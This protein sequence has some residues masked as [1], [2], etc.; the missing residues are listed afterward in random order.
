MVTFSG[1]VV[2]ITRMGLTLKMVT[3]AN[4]DLD[5]DEEAYTDGDGEKWRWKRR[6]QMKVK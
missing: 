2:A 4:E 5:G 3:E 1:L 6:T